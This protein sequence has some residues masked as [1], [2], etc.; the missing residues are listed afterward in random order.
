M[1]RAREAFSTSIEIHERLN[2][3]FGVFPCLGLVRVL[4]HCGEVE[5]A[6]ERVRGALIDCR[7][8]GGR[9]HGYALCLGAICDV[10]LGDLDAAL[11]G[12]Q[13]AIEV[14]GSDRMGVDEIHADLDAILRDPDARLLH[15]IMA[16][17]IA[18][19]G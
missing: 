18:G 13:S 3:A 4:L 17:L 14:W 8:L 15:P 1:D 2:S 7:D 6:A 10:R 9:V 5:A 11:A 19:E 16:L 12:F